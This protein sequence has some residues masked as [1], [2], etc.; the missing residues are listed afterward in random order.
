MPS[1]LE[2]GIELR[3][4]RRSIYIAQSTMFHPQKEES[5]VD[6]KIYPKQALGEQKKKR[7]RSKIPRKEVNTNFK[8][9]PCKVLLKDCT[10][11][12]ESPEVFKTPVTSVKRRAPV[13][14]DKV[15][16]VKLE[17][18]EFYTPDTTPLGNRKKISMNSQPIKFSLSEKTA[19][20]KPNVSKIPTPTRSQKKNEET[21]NL[22]IT[23][24][25]TL[26]NPLPEE[27]KEQ[28]SVDISI[29]TSS[30]DNKTTEQSSGSCCV[31]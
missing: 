25:D 18:E 21:S 29:K 3:R 9:T 7:P 10:K 1:N 12:N 15:K 4:T 6:P 24:A 8:V 14:I 2:E 30:P 20:S 5:S 19:A 17:S 13:S 26:N 31:M 16:R 27:K 28:L 22:F 11:D 23:K